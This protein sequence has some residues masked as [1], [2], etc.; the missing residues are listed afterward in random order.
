[1]SPHVHLEPRHKMLQHLDG[2]ALKGCQ[3][4]AKTLRSG[5]ASENRLYNMA[6]RKGYDKKRKLEADPGQCTSCR[7]LKTDV[8]NDGYSTK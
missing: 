6:L 7:K 1:M 5:D 2:G 4:P 8:S 3:L